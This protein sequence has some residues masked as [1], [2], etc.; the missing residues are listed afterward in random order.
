M[1]T[2]LISGAGLPSW[3]WDDVR[4]QLGETCVAARPSH[5]AGLRAYAEAALESAPDGRFAIVAHSAGG[6]I[7]AELAALA[8]DRV[9]AFLAVSAVIP[10]ARGS[11]LSA[12][13]APNRWLLSAVM[14]VAGTRPPNSAIQRGLAHGLD[15]GTTARLIADFTP[16][17]PVL[18]RGRT[19]HRSWTGARGYIVTDQ[20]RELPPAIQRTS[21]ER[22]APT[23]TTHLTTGHLPMLEDPKALAGAITQ[24]LDSAQ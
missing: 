24:F 19:T 16:E 3:I 13:P 15:A 21:A 11:F 8:P 22:L 14:R 20:D 23:W 17:S 10:Q 2:L 12:L 7:G 1:N 5:G 18:Y 4:P 6:V 9:S